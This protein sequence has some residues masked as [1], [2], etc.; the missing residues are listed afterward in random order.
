MT[1]LNAIPRLHIIAVNWEGWAINGK[2][3]LF[4]AFL[5]ETHVLKHA[6]ENV[7]WQTTQSKASYC[8]NEDLLFHLFLLFFYEQ[9]SMKQW[10]TMAD[11]QYYAKLKAIKITSGLLQVGFLA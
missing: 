4:F 3:E 8:F 6:H 5:A 2:A 10:N 1:F 11:V 9:I 7:V